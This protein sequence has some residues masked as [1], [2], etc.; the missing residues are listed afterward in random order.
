VFDTFP[1]PQAPEPDAADRVINAAVALI[2]CRNH[3]L[4]SGVTYARQYA[5]WD[6]PG[7]NDLRDA[8][9]KLDR[10]VLDAYGFDPSEDLLAQ[11]LALNLSIADEERQGN[12]VRPPGPVG[13]DRP[14]RSTWMIQP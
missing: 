13:V 3:L 11:L 4:A 8:H 14:R 12:P 10:A 1:W 6:D 2:S 9:E 5:T 7:R